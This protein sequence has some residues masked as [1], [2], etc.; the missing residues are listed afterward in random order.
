MKI[1]L[2]SNKVAVFFGLYGDIFVNNEN[3]FQCGSS[4]LAD[5]FPDNAELIEIDCPEY[6]LTHTYKLENSSWT[7][8]N[9]AALDA[10]L[11]NKKQDF[12]AAQKKSREAAYIAESDPINFMYQRGEATQQEWLDKVANIKTRFAYKE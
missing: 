11:D 7:C 4:I 8:I 9:Q 2:D 1:I 3:R 6:P 12:N 10:Y 5:Y